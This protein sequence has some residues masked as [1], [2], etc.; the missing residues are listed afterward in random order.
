PSSATARPIHQVL[1]TVDDSR[2]FNRCSVSLHL[3]SSLA[4]TGRLV[5][6]TR[7]YVVRAAP[8]LAPNPGS[9]LPSTSTGHCDGQRRASHPARNISA[10]RRTPQLVDQQQLGSGVEAHGGCPAT[11]EGGLVAAGGDVGG[12]GEVGA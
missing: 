11:L 9:G 12:G 5:V 8:G 3:P 10:S 7:P 4:G 6:P 2:G 1:Q